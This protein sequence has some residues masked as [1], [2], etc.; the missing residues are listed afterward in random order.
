MSNAERILDACI[1]SLSI[2]T[3]KGSNLTADSD[4]PYAIG[5][6]EVLHK[7][8]IPLMESDILRLLHAYQYDEKNA[9]VVATLAVSIGCGDLYEIDYQRF[10]DSGRARA[11]QHITEHEPK[12]QDK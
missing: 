7:Q 12:P 4:I 10:Y 3:N 1:K 5:L 8:G 9:E 6:F 2:R 11:I